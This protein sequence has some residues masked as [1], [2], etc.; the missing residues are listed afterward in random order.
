MFLICFSLTAVDLC[1]FAD[2]FVLGFEVLATLVFVAFTVVSETAAFVVN[3]VVVSTTS[4]VHVVY[5]TVVFVWSL[6]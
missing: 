2:T 1:C 3:A 6:I 4:V 5:S